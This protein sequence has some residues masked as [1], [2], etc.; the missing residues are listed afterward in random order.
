MS[1]VERLLGTTNLPVRPSPSYDTLERATLNSKPSY[2]SLNVPDTDSYSHDQSFVDSA[3]TPQHY[4][5]PPRYQSL[6]HR[7]SSNVLGL[8][9]RFDE[10]G[11]ESSASLNTRDLRSERSSATL[12]S[13][14]DSHRAPL[15]VSQQTSESAVRDMALRKGLSPVIPVTGEEYEDYLS[16]DTYG[17]REESVAPSVSTAREQGPRKLD[18]TTFFPR[19]GTS[20]SNAQ[21]WTNVVT[22]PSQLSLTSDYPPQGWRANLMASPSQK[23]PRTNAV[24]RKPRPGADRLPKPM[25]TASSVRGDETHDNP[26]NNVRRPPKGIQNWFDGL[27][28]EVDDEF[29]TDEDETSQ[30]LEQLESTI[31]SAPSVASTLSDEPTIDTLG[32]SRYFNSQLPSAREGTRNRFFP[33]NP[34]RSH[35]PEGTFRPPPVF[36][37]ADADGEANFG[38]SDT[39]DESRSRSTTISESPQQSL[40][41]RPDPDPKAPSLPLFQPLSA[42]DVPNNRRSLASY[43]TVT[44]GSTR[45]SK[46]ADMDLKH[47]SA[48]SLS[49]SSDGDADTEEEEFNPSMPKVRDSIAI[50]EIS[51][52][53]VQIGKARAFQIGS[54]QGRYNDVKRAPRPMN[55]RRLPPSKISEEIPLEPRSAG[56]TTTL[57]PAEGTLSKFAASEEVPEPVRPHTSAA[58]AARNDQVSNARLSGKRGSVLGEDTDPTGLGHKLMAVTPEEEALLEMMRSKRVAMVNHSFKE[59]YKTALRQEENRKSSQPASLSHDSLLTAVEAVVQASAARRQGKTNEAQ[60]T[61]TTQQS[62]VNNNEKNDADVTTESTFTE[63]IDS[64]PAPS[65]TGNR[66]SASLLTRT[67]QHTG[68]PGLSATSSSGHVR[69]KRNSNLSNFSSGMDDTSGTSATS[70]SPVMKQHLVD[71]D[72]ESTSGDLSNASTVKKK[73]AIQRLSLA[74]VDVSIGSSLSRFA[75]SNQSQTS[76][77]FGDLTIGASESIVGNNDTDDLSSAKSI[78]RVTSAPTPSPHQTD[79]ESMR[80][81]ERP[82]SMLVNV[83]AK[84]PSRPPSFA[85]PESPRNV[86]ERRMSKGTE[87]KLIPRISQT[88]SSAMSLTSPSHSSQASTKLQTGIHKRRITPERLH[89]SHKIVNAVPYARPQLVATDPASGAVTGQAVHSPTSGRIPKSHTR[90]ISNDKKAAPRQP[91]PSSTTAPLSRMSS[92]SKNSPTR[93]SNSIL[94]AKPGGSLPRNSVS[95]DVLNAWSNLGGW[96]GFEAMRGGV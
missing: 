64:F 93:S 51:S 39:S 84:P 21:G 10:Q 19:P 24:L 80:S 86:P 61:N 43:N 23:G 41:Y 59:G 77:V 13:Y 57:A 90:N 96:R 75:P 74:P 60:A 47:A 65:P 15:L 78:T 55:L 88:S 5:T 30:D 16:R 3:G 89:M 35:P 28:E 50:S 8:S 58:D 33:Q 52:D 17:Q 20:N 11:I 34:L 14:Y 94:H 7:A 27:L 70:S 66:F 63:I 81:S 29:G 31:R 45:T 72:Q 25:S 18:I 32:T 12:R 44:S 9:G 53:H 2:M 37:G 95:E 38:A 42:P 79:N 62:S 4:R 71:A 85:A 49:S 91:G 76:S 6:Q 36:R 56:P 54:S 67:D 82:A 69:A 83:S 1:K 46:L 92:D 48:L 40:Q 87:Y 68:S 73:E 22:S 26:K